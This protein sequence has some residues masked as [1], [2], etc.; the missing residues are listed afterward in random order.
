MIKHIFKEILPLAVAQL[1]KMES[2]SEMLEC[3]LL[4]KSVGVFV[5]LL[6]MVKKHDIVDFVTLVQY[7]LSTSAAGAEKDS[8]LVVTEAMRKR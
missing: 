6:G 7:L 5:K 8:L 1:Q 2:M 3:E 4:R